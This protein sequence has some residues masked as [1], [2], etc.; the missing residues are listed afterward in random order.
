L[1]LFAISERQQK[2][3]SLKQNSEIEQLTALVTFRFA[4]GKLLAKE[5]I[6]VDGY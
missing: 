6:D 1:C 2:S 4:S 3:E 5:Q